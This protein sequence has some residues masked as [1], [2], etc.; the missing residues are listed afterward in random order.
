MMDDT[1]KMW[2]TKY[3]GQLK[4]FAISDVDFAYCKDTESYFPTFIMKKKGYET[5]KVEV[6]R[7][8]EGNGG[9]FLFISENKKGGSN[10]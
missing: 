8:E 6:S 1:E 7:D 3:Y 2:G 4:G 10:G 5:I 9:G